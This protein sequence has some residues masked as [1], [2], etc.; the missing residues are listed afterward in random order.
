MTDNKFKDIVGGSHLQI[1][2]KN[3]KFE[4][5]RFGKKASAALFEDNQ[6]LKAP[7]NI[8]LHQSFSLLFWIRFEPNFPAVDV[9]RFGLDEI[10]NCLINFA[11]DHGDIDMIVKL[12]NK[13]R[14]YFFLEGKTLNPWNLVSLNVNQ[15]TGTF[16]FD[17]NFFDL[18]VSNLM[19]KNTL[20]THNTIGYIDRNHSGRSFVLDDLKIYRG[21][22]SS[23]EIVKE[24]LIE[25]IGLQ[26]F[27][28]FIFNIFNFD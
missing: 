13:E 1:S 18:K 17:G 10:N 19:A 12:V 23:D 8:Y 26:V 27:S 6:F 21:T 15:T 20:L 24:L 7:E 25:G 14:N 4:E 28:Y 11:E 3:F 22:L 5:N 16:H 9:I 2:G